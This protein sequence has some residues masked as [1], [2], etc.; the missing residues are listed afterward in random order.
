MLKQFLHFDFSHDLIGRIAD[1]LLE[2]GDQLHHTTIV[3]PGKRPGLYLR[4][5]LAERLG[6]SFLPPKIL[7]VDE[8]MQEISGYPHE[9]MLGDVEAA[10]L[11]QKLINKFS[12]NA[13]SSLLAKHGSFSGFFFWGLELFRLFEEFLTENLDV[14]TVRRLS[15][16]GVLEEGPADALLI[17]SG[18]TELYASWLAELN[19]TGLCTRGSVYKESAAI[20]QDPFP[21][22]LF[23][24]A[25][26]FALTACELAVFKHVFSKHE[27]IFAVQGEE[28]AATEFQF[29]S[30]RFECPIT[31][32]SRE[33]KR[34]TI[35][36]TPSS[37]VQHQMVLVRQELSASD[38]NDCAVVLPRSESLLPFLWEVANHLPEEYNISLTYPLQRTSLY[39]LMEKILVLQETQDSGRYYFKALISLLS[40]PFV[41]NLKLQSSTP[42]DTRI[43]IHGLCR[44]TESVK[45]DFVTIVELRNRLPGNEFPEDNFKGDEAHPAGPDR[46]AMFDEICSRLITAFENIRTLRGLIER[47]RDLIFYLAANSEGTRY[48][49]SPEFW[50]RFSDLF[51]SLLDSDIITGLPEDEPI[52]INNILRYIIQNETVGFRGTPLRGYQV[53]G[54]LEVRSLRFRKVI[55]LDLNE[56]VIPGVRKFEPFLSPSLRREIGL[57]TYRE[58]ERIFRHYTRAALLGCDEAVVFYLSGGDKLRSRF[59]EE[60]IWDQ[61]KSA[62]RIIPEDSPQTFMLNLSTASSL[63]LKKSPFV[64]K[65]IRKT[66]VSPTWIDSYLRCPLQFYFGFMLRIQENSVSTPEMKLGT[67]IHKILEILFQGVTSFNRSTAKELKKIL[68]EVTD[69]VFSEQFQVIE[70]E[71]LI[72]KKIAIMRLDRMLDHD[73][74]RSQETPFSIRALET[75]YQ[76]ELPGIPGRRFTG[77]VDRLEEDAGGLLRIVDY[78][79]GSVDKLKPQSR[80]MLEGEPPEDRQTMRELIH[81]FQLPLYMHMLQQETGLP[82]ENLDAAWYSVRDCKFIR[83][84]GKETVEQRQA[85]LDV[86]LQSCRI[87]LEEMSDPDRPFENTARDE[88]ECSKCPYRHLC[89]RR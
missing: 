60:M 8:M 67:L 79:T 36:F 84:F 57:P 29:L 69:R 78:K 22:G 47:F 9:R 53:L 77:K 11:L 58:R 81:S 1:L 40:H 44:M 61:E 86:C 76:V 51:Q 56:G 64:L 46:V 24:A 75:K 85:V 12:G 38:L 19:T 41:K 80:K 82:W 23:I 20:D 89:L 52:Q 88:Q 16:A 43:M 49:F 3:F 87:L 4:K 30:D 59:A 17:W 35:R 71:P 48:Y 37:G 70:G 33:Q 50:E 15:E 54:P 14:Q 62:G 74:R 27:S 28:P 26:F 42:A 63:S 68:P 25:G 18:M 72:V 45:H 32:I 66:R 55:F 83:L 2:Q 21:E 39:S 5:K 10:V 31:L 34:P 13:V 7:S 65:T 73:S 6:K